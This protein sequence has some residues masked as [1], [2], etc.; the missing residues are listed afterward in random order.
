MEAGKT[1]DA[2]TAQKV[3]TETKGPRNF[4]RSSSLVC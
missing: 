2:D 1:D 3:E 4:P